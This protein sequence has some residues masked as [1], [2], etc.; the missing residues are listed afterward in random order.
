[1]KTATDRRDYS[2]SP[3]VVTF[4][5]AA[6]LRATRAVVYRKLKKVEEAEKY[7][8]KGCDA[9]D[10]AP[11]DTDKG[12]DQRETAL[13]AKRDK[14][15]ERVR[16]DVYFSTGYFYYE[17]DQLSEARRYLGKAIEQ[18]K[19]SVTLWDSPITREAI[20]NMCNGNHDTALVQFLEARTICEQT[21]ATNREASL[22][23]ALCGLGL[24]IL[25]IDQQLGDGASMLTRNLLTLS[26]ANRRWTRAR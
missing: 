11:Q 1:M 24:A 17:R 21:D 10:E 20:V 9:C 18:L 14:S 4:E 7:Y 26:S 12:H 25:K 5:Q 13:Y 2:S 22:T 8:K 23:Y 15:I 19:A 3:S 6:Q 16:A